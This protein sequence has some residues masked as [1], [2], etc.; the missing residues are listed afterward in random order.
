VDFYGSLDEKGGSLILILQYDEALFF[1]C[2]DTSMEP[3]AI[4]SFRTSHDL[5]ILRDVFACH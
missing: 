4:N 3:K 2:F 5:I 1:I